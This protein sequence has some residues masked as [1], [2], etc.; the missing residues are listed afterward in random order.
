MSSKY[1]LRGRG[2]LDT[3]LI[4]LESWYLEHKYRVIYH[5]Y[6]WC[7]SWPHL[8]CTWSGTINVLQVWTLRRFFFYTLLIMLE[9]WNLAYK[10]WVIYHED[11]WCKR[12]TH[13]PRTFLGTINFL[14]VW[15]LRMEGS[16]HTSNHARELKFGTK[17]LSHITWGCRR[18]KMT[19]SSKYL[20]RNLQRPLSMDFKDEEFL[21]HF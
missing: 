15:T 2:I 5:E 17:W 3:L 18:S 20:V 13:P 12:C 7:K 16:W 10:Y 19:L 4:M 6:S 11:S 14:Q 8:T 1:R 9:S 21:T